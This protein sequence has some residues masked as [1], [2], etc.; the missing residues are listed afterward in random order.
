MRRGQWLVAVVALA[1]MLG[2]AGVLARLKAAQHLGEPGVKTTPIPGSARVNIL[3]P[4]EVLGYTSEPVETPEEVLTA[5]PADTSFAQRRYRAQDGFETALNVVL[6]GGDRTSIHKPQFC[7]TGAGWHI[8]QT[9]R[10][11]VRIYRPHPYDLPV[12]KI[13][14]SRDV[15][16]AG[17]TRTWRG[18]YVYWFVCDNAISGE[19]SGFE[20]MW[21]MARELLRTG[22]LQRWAYVTCFSVCPP[23][24]EEETF[25]RMQRF[26][27][28]AVPEF[29]LVPRPQTDAGG[30]SAS[31]R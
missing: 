17:Q 18:V 26:I 31:K 15:A 2:A 4:E 11:Q 10:E 22:V 25:K 19:P 28:L 30:Q 23:G 9:T 1:M 6:M 7:L 21:W 20:R 27:A 24:Q 14:A 29:Q 8:D 12:V 16:V 5:L 3:L 13:L